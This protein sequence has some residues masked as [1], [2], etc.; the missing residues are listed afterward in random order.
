MV[1]LESLRREAEVVVEGTA[2]ME[3]VDMRTTPS[4]RRHTASSEQ[5]V[6]NPVSAVVCSSLLLHDPHLPSYIADEAMLVDLDAVY[7][8]HA[9]PADV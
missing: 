2:V 6:G 8:K 7:W 5:K 4:W 9:G 3:A 1:V